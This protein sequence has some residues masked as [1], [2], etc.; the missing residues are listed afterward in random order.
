MV[1]V[2]SMPPAQPTYSS[3][4]VSLSRLSKYLPFNSPRFRPK[5]PVMP[6]SSSV[7]IRASIGP[8]LMVLLSSTAM[9]AATPKPSSAP[10]VV[11]QAYTQPSTILV[12]MGSFRKS[13]TLPARAWGTMSIW[14]CSTTGHTSSMPGVAG[15]RIMILPTLSTW[16]S[17]L[18]FFAQSTR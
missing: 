3:P 15:L 14:A 8:C 4:S 7:V 17:I 12:S 1:M 9:A 10:R 18:C 11:S 6:V 5:A 16:H 13:C 2:A